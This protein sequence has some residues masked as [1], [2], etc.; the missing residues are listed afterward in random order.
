MRS[1]DTAR[2][3]ACHAARERHMALR[4]RRNCPGPDG[5]R[6]LHA[7]TTPKPVIMPY[8]LPVSVAVR[9]SA[10]FCLRDLATMVPDPGGR[11]PPHLLEARALSGLIVTLSA[12][13]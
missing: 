4:A 9:S 1:A 5:A 11:N 8:P 7:R 10:G 3:H 6:R 2:W 12:Q 13:G